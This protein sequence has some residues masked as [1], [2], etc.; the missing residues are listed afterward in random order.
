MLQAYILIQTQMCKAAGVATAVAGFEGVI[1][2]STLSGPY[3]VIA[4]TRRGRRRAWPAHRGQGPVRRGHR[5]YSYLPSCT[6]VRPILTGPRDG[7]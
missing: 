6:A 2:V 3:D 1:S 7:G 5:A 4:V